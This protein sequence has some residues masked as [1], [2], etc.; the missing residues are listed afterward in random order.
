MGL[1][2]WLGITLFIPPLPAAPLRGIHSN[3]SDIHASGADDDD[4]DASDFAFEDRNNNTNGSSSVNSTVSPHFANASSFVWWNLEWGMVPHMSWQERN[5]WSRTLSQATTYMEFGGGG[6]T[7]WALQHYQKLRVHTVDSHPGWI[8][9]LRK[10]PVVRQALAEGRLVLKHANIG[11]V[12]AWG[13]PKFKSTQRHWP[14]YSDEIYKAKESSHW[15]VVFVDGRFRVACMLKAVDALRKRPGAD[16]VRIVT[17]DYNNRQ[18][19]WPVENFLQRVNSAD[20]LVVFKIRP[21]ISDAHL[22]TVINQYE[23]VPQLF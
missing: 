2:Q 8:K 6:S 16:G 22:Q 4:Y 14:C 20:T 15:D 19:Y 17:H 23:S 10:M 5:L 12:K 9:K 1:L 13:Y 7:V 3:H 18:Q 21:A 11:P